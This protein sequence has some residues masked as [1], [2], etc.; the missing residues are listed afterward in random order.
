[1]RAIAKRIFMNPNALLITIFLIAIAKSGVWI[2]GN[3]DA[4]RLIAENPFANPFEN[5][6]ADY[7]LN[8]WL[9]NFIAFLLHATKPVNFFVL[10]LVFT[11]LAILV[12]VFTVRNKVQPKN[13]NYAS[14][15][16]V[17]LPVSA[18]VFYWIGMDGFLLLLFVTYFALTKKA[19]IVILGALI[20]MQHFEIGII[21]AAS[22]FVYE[23][24]KNKEDSE[25]NTLLKATIL[26][27]GI[28]IGKIV[29]II[30]FHVN[31]VTVRENR[32]T[33]GFDSAIHK[34]VD[35]VRYAPA[36]IFSA[37]GILWILIL[38]IDRKEQKAFLVAFAL[39]L[40]ASFFVWDQT[41]ILQ[42]SSILIVMRAFVLN[43]KILDRVNPQ[44]IKSFFLAWLIVP[45]IWIWQDF[46]GPITGFNIMIL[47]SRIFNTN[48]APDNSELF[49]WIFSRTLL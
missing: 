13:Q 34:L 16:F 27:L 43:E 40:V 46:L 41:R 6:N 2:M 8:S 26:L 5:S 29:L 20:G 9:L 21:A 28:L 47:I 1:M 48:T 37:L 45:W 18:G 12:G 19:Q 38:K 3:L 7:L 32:Y 36:A 24:M 31:Q 11:V 4:T 33:L 22:L 35:I 44:E 14:Y 39:P 42:Q 49:W 17:M 15:M 25:K 23:K 30:I 10:H